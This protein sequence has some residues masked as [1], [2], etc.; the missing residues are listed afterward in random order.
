MISTMPAP[1]VAGHLAA[2]AAI[3]QALSDAAATRSRDVARFDA[4][5]S[6]KA[7]EDAAA[8]LGVSVEAV[9]RA[10]ARLSDAERQDLLRRADA[11]R[12]DPVA[13]YMDRDIHQLLVILL[14]VVIVVVVLQAV[15]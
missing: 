10:A 4:L 7:T 9:R 15:D 6:D 8:R 3:D 11:L 14:I 13:G 5:L 2:P 1:A 12:Q